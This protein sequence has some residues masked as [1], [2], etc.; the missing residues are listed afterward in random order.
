MPP[1]SGFSNNTFGTRADLVQATL[2]LLRPLLPHFSPSKGRIRIPVSSATHFDE[3]AAQ[4]EGFARPL[5]AVGALLLGADATSD[6]ALSAAITEVVQPWIDGFV[7]GTDPEHPEYWGAIKGPDQRMVE[8][9]IVAFALLSAPDRIY[10][11]LSEK[12][13][14]NVT[15]WLRSLNGMEMPKNNWRWFRVFGNL[16]LFKV[17]GVPYESIREEIN[18]DLALLDTFY[19]FDGWS[20]DGP[21]QTPEQAQDEF[22]QFDKT[23]RRDAIG[24]GRQAD[25]YSG[26]FAIQFSQ[27]LY[28]RFAAD[29]DPE[30]AEIY[31]QRAR[32]FGVTFWRYF[33]SEGSAIPFG[34]SLTYRFACGGYFAALAL[35]KVPDMPKPLHTPGAIK[36]FLL[37][38]LRWWANNSDGVFYPDGTMNIGWLYPNMYMCEDYNSPQSP[39]WCLKTLIAVGL[40]EN[41]DFWTAEEESYPQLSSTD[42]V[43]L[44]PAPQQIV[45]NH[46]QSNHH[47]LLSPGQFVAWPMK[48]NQAKYCKFAYSSAFTFSVP[49]GPLIQQIAPDNALAL[50]RDGGETWAV[51][52]K[53]EPVRFSTAFIETS[54]GT[55]EVQ[56]ASAKWYPWGDRA[57]SVDTTLIPPSDRWPDWHVRLHR[58]KVHEKLKT[59]HTIEG[60]FAI[61]GRRQADGLP[62]P[63]ISD[64]PQDASLGSAEGVLQKELS[65]LILSSAGASGVVSKSLSSPQTTSESFPLKPDSNTNLACPR[66]LIPVVSHATV[67]GLDAGFEIVFLESIF[68]LSTSANSGWRGT[69]KTVAERWLDAPRVQLVSDYP[70]TTDGDIMLV[71][72]STQD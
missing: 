43:A 1:L 41:D 48:A 27:L 65:T 58:I 35:A 46:P 7:A 49:T 69:G 45:C 23:G 64:I 44:V 18:S 30:R 5:W 24:I 54:S 51:K 71:V 36:G 2:A 70:N 20:A 34:R 42:S 52:W 10:K 17:C 53:S 8:A 61:S 60:G 21:W 59:L 31:R 40:A 66:T 33:D 4:L 38:H 28:S 15:N 11:P 22:E 12:S 63:I 25:Y 29:I 68:A 57:V 56:A 50:S 47:F 13:K 19:R 6:S 55:Q 16:A 72:A 32:G 9:E 26:S 37:R 39:Y 14:E 67:G 3:T 62:L